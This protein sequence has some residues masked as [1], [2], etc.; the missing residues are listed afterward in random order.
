MATGLSL[1]TSRIRPSRSAA[2]GVWGVEQ[3]EPRADAGTSR[4]EARG[5]AATVSPIGGEI[6]RSREQS[7]NATGGRTGALRPAAVR[8]LVLHSS[9]TEDAASTHI[10]IAPRVAISASQLAV[11]ATTIYL[12]PARALR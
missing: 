5:R 2:F 1:P 11:F 6:E 4:P 12:H 7:R 3:G 10:R 8:R 9:W